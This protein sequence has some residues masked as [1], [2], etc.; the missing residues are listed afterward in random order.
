MTRAARKML[1]RLKKD[2][3]ARSIELWEVLGIYDDS[4]AGSAVIR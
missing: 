3:H 4:K 1:S 2:S